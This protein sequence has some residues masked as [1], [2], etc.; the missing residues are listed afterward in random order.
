MSTAY[1]QKKV[2][3]L[4]EILRE[5]ELSLGGTKSELIARLEENDAQRAAQEPAKPE[6]AEEEPAPAAA[7]EEPAVPEQVPE[8]AAEAVPEEAPKMTAEEAATHTVTSQMTDGELM[9]QVTKELEQKIQRCIRFGGDP[10]PFEE[11]LRRI[12]RF[13]ISAIRDAAAKSHVP[14]ERKKFR[15]PKKIGQRS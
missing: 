15:R 10:K 14:V 2:N 3:E 8:P 11:R 9:A 5:R 4:K 12:Q 7:A 6:P 13:G 1:A